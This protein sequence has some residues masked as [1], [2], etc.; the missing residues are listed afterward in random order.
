METVENKQA[1]TKHQ[2]KIQI[3]D[4]THLISNTADTKQ[5]RK[6]NQ[7][8]PSSNRAKLAK[9]FSNLNEANSSQANSNQA[10]HADT[11]G[12]SYQKAIHL[13]YVP[14]MFCNLD[15]S[16]CY[17]GEQTST[18]NLKADSETAIS[19]LHH[20]LNQLEADGILAFNVSLHGGEV[21]T[22]QPDIL[23]TLFYTIEQYYLKHF[24]A[25]TA[26]GF[27]KTEPHIKT[28]LYKFAD[29][30]DLLDDYKVSISASIDLPL[31]LHDEHR[32]LKNGA[33][34]RKRTEK[35]L[36][37]LAQ[38]PHKKKISATL[39]QEHLHHTQEII[40]DIW[41]IHRELGFDMSNFNLMFA[42]ESELNDSCST[43]ISLTPAT[44]QQHN[45][46]YQAL[47]QAFV[48][49]ELEVGLRR[50]WFDEF[51]PSYCTNSI[52]CGEKFYLLQGDGDVYS[53]VRGQGVKEFF[54]GNIFKESMAEITANGASK[55]N[56]IHQTLGFDDDCSGCSHLSLCHTGCPV[57][58]FQQNSAKS[59]T[60]QLQKT[61]Y[62]DNPL[63]FEALSAEKQPY[64][65]SYYQKLVHPHK[66][67]SGAGASVGADS[68]ITGLN[69]QVFQP[70]KQNQTQTALKTESQT[71]SVAIAN[72]TQN[73]TQTSNAY[74][75]SRK[76]DSQTTETKTPSKNGVNPAT[77]IKNANMFQLPNDIVDAK[78]ALPAIIADDAN[79]TQLY[80]ND[81][82][83]LQ[84]N[85]EFIPLTSQI[86]KPQRRFYSIFD[87]DKVIIHVAS[88]IFLANCKER[89]RN[90]LYMQ[91]LTDKQVTYGD[92]QRQKQAHLFTHQLW[93]DYLTESPLTNNHNESQVEN[94]TDSQ[95]YLMTDITDLIGLYKSH[96]TP[97]ERLNLFF[98]TQYLRD[99]HYQKHKNNAFY[100]IQAINLPFQN[101]EFYYGVS[102]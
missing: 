55:I 83:I 94:Q 63:T 11:H 32:V 81:A 15:C 17:L 9:Q 97:N 16:Y 35:N 52:N 79:L 70:Q 102:P 65:A 69:A 99:Y 53:C 54:Y 27:R 49:T 80:R 19:T 87:T 95:S 98:T 57:V 56:Q 41:Y 50:H 24:D 78:N 89:L 25:L 28:N 73:I 85:D 86:L 84:I 48:G 5:P 2:K 38:Y 43:K 33:S 93:V 12:K 26:R 72:T 20:A 40:D 44:Q 67:F 88:D 51:S 74:D 1:Q 23:E 29:L 34:W 96:Y 66:A 13:L 92:E 42:F 3:K 45:T 77:D 100:H 37:L 46:L 59:Y 4:V 61:W 47:Y 64:Y 30:Y 91:M 10:W 60:C 76:Q 71:Q 39:S 8:K 14:T 6:E 22:L 68:R 31:R 7:Q 62:K 90:T 82:F 36:Q 21:T 75:S 58:K 18:A 101:I